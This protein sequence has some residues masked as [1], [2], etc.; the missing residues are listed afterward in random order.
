MD[1]EVTA[2]VALRIDAVQDLLNADN[3]QLSEKQKTETA[4]LGCELGNF[5]EGKQRRWTVANQTEIKAVVASI[6]ESFETIALPYINQYSNL[7]EALK[8]L[9]RNDKTGWLHSPF[10]DYRCSKALILAFVLGKQDQVDLLEKQGNEFL[11]S[12]KDPRLKFFKQIVKK[13][14]SLRKQSKFGEI[15]TQ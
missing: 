13:I 15:H 8:V 9:S 14:N 10:H 5:F 3:S 1:F 7:D 2:D 6:S 11:E 4:T 12:H